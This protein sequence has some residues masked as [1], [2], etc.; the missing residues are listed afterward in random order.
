MKKL[1]LIFLL[2]ITCSTLQASSLKQV[3]FFGDSLTD[4]GNLYN[5]LFKIM[6]K[7]PP[8]YQG[9]FANG[10]AWSDYLGKFYSDKYHAS[11]LNYAVG[12]ATT[13]L[14][15]PFDGFLPYDLREETDKYITDYLFTDKSH[16]LFI[17]WMGA[18]DYLNG[19]SDV[20]KST[21]DVVNETVSVIQNLMFFGANQFVVLNL[22]D[23][24]KT[25]Y[26]KT[27][28]YGDN[29]HELTV[30]HNKKLADAVAQLHKS[31]P[32]KKFTYIDS[33]TIFEDII[34]NPE[35]YNEKYQIQISNMQDACWLG[36]YTLQHDE[37]Q[38]AISNANHGENSKP[39][40]AKLASQFVMNSP[41][42]K[43]AYATG[44]AYEKG[45]T[46]C[47]KPDTYVFWDKVHPTS[48]IHRIIAAI[49]IETLPP[50]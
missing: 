12:G 15:S 8:Y 48:V 7:S 34:E 26:A 47:E 13:I 50:I 22:P 14:R 37:L 42:L 10:P 43:E 4:N 44:K 39:L 40:N 49:V 25:P 32:D 31:H 5:G 17:I 24:A 16:S 9:R 18:N 35:K 11:Y 1:T 46:P 30:V 21:T 28:T 27:V 2:F 6:P 23:L 3:V 29:L 38:T 36:G 45:A 33:Y 41:A 19:Q 20:N